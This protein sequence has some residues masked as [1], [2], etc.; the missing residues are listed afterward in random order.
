M[1]DDGAYG[2]AVLVGDSGYS[3]SRY[4]MTPFDN[5]LSPA[6]QLYNEAQI[7]TRNPVERCFG[8]WKRRFPVLSLGLRVHLDKVF[9]IIVATTVLHNI[10]RRRGEAVPPFEPQFEANLPGPWD[11]IM[12]QGEMG[13]NPIAAIHQPLNRRRDHPDQRERLGMVHQYFTRLV[14][15]IIEH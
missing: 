9:P 1:F 3:C 8:I 7:R 13:E 4:M 10:L 12:A 2:N 15:A 6:E 5:C 11:I 14:F